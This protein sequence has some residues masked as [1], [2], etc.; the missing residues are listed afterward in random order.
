MAAHGRNLLHTKLKLGLNLDLLVAVG[1]RIQLFQPGCDGAEIRVRLR[2]ADA[3]LQTALHRNQRTSRRSRVFS[4]PRRGDIASGTNRAGFQQSG[5]MPVNRSGATPMIVHST[6]FSRMARA[7][8]RGIRV[9]LAHPEIVAQHHHRIPPDGLIF[10]VQES[11]SQSAGCT[12]SV[13]KK[14]PETNAP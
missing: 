14:F 10:G 4:R 7:H 6:P 2:D 9:K 1:L 12:P 8:Y 11:S 13:R 5:S 3:G